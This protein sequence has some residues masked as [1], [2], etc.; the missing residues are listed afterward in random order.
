MT[1]VRRAV[2]GDL[3]ALLRLVDEFCEIDRHPYDE[4][5]VRRGLEP[6]LADDALGQVWVA[7]QELDLLGYAVL[8]WG[9]GLETGGRE[10]LLDELY[11]SRRDDG[12][13]SQLLT[14]VLA[15]AG[16][17]GCLTVF[18]ETE[19][20]NEAARRFYR[21]HGFT[22]EESVWMSMDLPVAPER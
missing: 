19:R 9:W 1:R 6:L 3:P 11:V 13:G 2:P 7:I 18:L 4:A 12:I 20:P 5:H 16:A 17:G 22:R 8:T 15:Q 21:R 10:G 14:R